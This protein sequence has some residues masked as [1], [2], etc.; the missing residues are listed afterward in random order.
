MSAS[1]EL[2]PVIA[3]LNRLAIDNHS[4][5]LVA[6]GERE[7]ALIELRIQTTKL[8]PDGHAWAPWK[9]F[10]RAKRESQGNAEQ[11]LLWDTGSLLHSQTYVTPFGAAIEIGTDVDYAEHLQEG[12][13][14]RMEA[15]PFVGW[16]EDDKA[17]LES[18]L[19]EHLQALIG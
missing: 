15:R 2:G 10:T 11:G 14:G 12:I 6:V 1:I 18:S 7:K 19:V 13:E 4:A 17:W 9:P 16:S 3:A 5:W 8:D